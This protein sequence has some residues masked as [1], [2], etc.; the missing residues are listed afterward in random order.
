MMQ[1]SQRGIAG[2]SHIGC[3]RTRNEDSI[4]Y[5]LHSEHAFLLAVVADGMGG[6]AGGAVASQLAVQEYARAWQVLG[7]S[8][9]SQQW[10]FDTALEANRLIRLQAEADQRLKGMG[11]TLVSLSLRDDQVH[12]AHIGDSRCY[13]FRAGELVQLT[14]DH[15]LVQRMVDEGA[16]TAA[17]AE[18][19]P[20]RNYLTR[21]L[22]SHVDPL[23]DCCSIN[24]QSGDRLLLCSDGLTNMLSH[25]EIAALLQAA[26]ED[27]DTCASLLDLALARGASDNVSVIVC[28]V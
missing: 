10:L 7:E 17:E 28:T 16:L 25:S 20:M 3:V 18:R 6:H 8:P 9:A 5:Q 11:T 26:A 24:V 14:R 22:G 1:K 12:I 4:F 23:V 2:V 19:S 21:S 15:S 27:D 13:H